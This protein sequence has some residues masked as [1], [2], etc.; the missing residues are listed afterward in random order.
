MRQVT[1]F[2]SATECAP[3]AHDTFEPVCCSGRCSFQRVG[4]AER[5]EI[6]AFIQRGFERAY[7][8]RITRFMPGL[9]SLRRDSKLAAACGLRPAASGPLFLETYLDR[10]IERALAAA[11]GQ[12]VARDAITEVGNLV[13]ARPGHARRL[14]IHLTKHLHPGRAKWVV[15]TAVPALRNNFTRLGIPLLLL[16]AADGA[17]LDAAALADWGSYYEQAPCVTAVDV[18]AAFEAVRRTSCTR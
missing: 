3:A 11:C 17:R 14:V 16:A 1:D 2:R 7:R 18:A 13:V 10:P 6:E 4:A 8:A 12:P 5:P 9:M 15:F